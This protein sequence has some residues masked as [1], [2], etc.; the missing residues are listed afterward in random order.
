MALLGIE[1][2]APTRTEVRQWSDR[3]KQITVPVLPSM[4]LVR[5]AEQ[6]SAAVFDILGVVRYLFEKGK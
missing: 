5:I 1:V 2:Y 6:D 4:F 3:K